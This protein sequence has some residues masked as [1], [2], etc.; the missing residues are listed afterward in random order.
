MIPVVDT[1]AMYAGYLV[2]G[3]LGMVVALKVGMRVAYDSVVSDEAKDLAAQVDPNTDVPEP[4]AG[5]ASEMV[6]A[7]VRDLAPDET[8]RAD[9]EPI[10]TFD[11]STT[12]ATQEDIEA[13]LYDLR[14]AGYHTH[15]LP[16][17]EHYQDRHEWGRHMAGIWRHEPD[18]HIVAFDE[19]TGAKTVKESVDIPLPQ[20][21][22]PEAEA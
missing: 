22:E 16:K 6:L 20:Q 3:G 18:W 13:V 11:W 1:V 19:E 15:P 17:I 2:L 10:V 21:W 7:E 9:P 5:V 14:Q 8:I 12:P 4:V